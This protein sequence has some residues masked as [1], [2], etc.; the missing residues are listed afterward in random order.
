MLRLQWYYILLMVLVIFFLAKPATTFADIGSGP[1][2]CTQSGSVNNINSLNFGVVDPLS[3]SATTSTTLNYECKGSEGRDSTARIC[4]T[5][6]P[7]NSNRHYELLGPSNSLL[8]F[9]LFSDPNFTKPITDDE[10]LQLILTS[11]NNTTITGSI[12]VYAQV[13]A[14]QTKLIAGNYALQ[15]QV[16]MTVNSI[17]GRRAPAN[18]IAVDNST[19]TYEFP[20]DSKASVNAYCAVTTTGALNLGRVAATTTP[21]SGTASNLINVNCTNETSYNI[22]LAPAAYKGVVNNNGVGAMRG[23]RGDIDVVHYQLQ[24][25]ESGTVWGNNGNTY[26]TLTNGVAGQ[27]NGTSQTHTVYVTVP[28]TDVKPD[29]YS[30]IV[31]I[32]VNY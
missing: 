21:I 13:V 15:N 9:S 7:L 27:G 4:Y 25:N 23:T 11:S 3:S 5:F 29:V 26:A 20:Y 14:G 6:G 32:N 12:T 8:A 30:D 2:S 19:S 16:V 1:V 18:C 24:S 17:E 31:T 22:G 28:N 10:P